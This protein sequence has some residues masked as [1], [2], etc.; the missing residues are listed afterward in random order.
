MIAGGITALAV[1]LP[2]EW[3]WLKISAAITTLAGSG[4]AWEAK[5]RSRLIFQHA[6]GALAAILVD[7]GSSINQWIVDLEAFL[8]PDDPIDYTDRVEKILEQ[9]N[10]LFRELNR[11]QLALVTL[12]ASR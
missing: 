4:F 2:P 9:A 3:L 5:R 12:T 6:P 1:F 11:A 8:N 10:N 7:A